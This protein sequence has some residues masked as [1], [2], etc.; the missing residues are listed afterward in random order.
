LKRMGLTS[1]VRASCYAYTSA[2]EVDRLIDG[3]QRNA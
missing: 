3:L 1:A 2:E